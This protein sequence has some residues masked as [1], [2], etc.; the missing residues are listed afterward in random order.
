MF[1]IE[2]GRRMHGDRFDAELATRSQDAKRNLAAIGN[3]N[4]F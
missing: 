2:I 1:L 4:F 3:D